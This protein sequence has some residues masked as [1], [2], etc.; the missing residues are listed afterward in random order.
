MYLSRLLL[1][2]QRR[3]VQHDLGDVHALHRR[4][5]TAF[6]LRSA[7]EPGARAQFGVLYRLDERAVNAPQ[8]L[9][10]SQE[11]PDWTLLP[12]GYLLDGLDNPACKPVDDFYAA[13]TPGTVLRF[14]L[15]ANPTRRVFQLKDGEDAKWRGKRVELQGGDNCLAWLQRKGEQHGF[16]LLVSGRQ[17]AF[18]DV[19]VTD[20]GKLQ[21]RRAE[22]SG[23]IRLTL[24]AVRFD[25]RLTITDVDRFRDALASGI[26][27][28]KAYGFGLLSVAREAA[29]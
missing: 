13:L 11:Q 15:R 12:Q 3:D 2:P 10:Q 5:L 29:P 24:A 8:V 14:R 23:P 4:L 26:G 21:G 18:G 7:D 25:G 6:P 1:D 20:E 9:V 19:R 28:G 22:Q 16:A 17:P 27:S